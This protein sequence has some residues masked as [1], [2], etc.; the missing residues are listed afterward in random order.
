[1]TDQKES[2]RAAIIRLLHP[3]P[4]LAF[5]ILIGV[6]ALIAASV[7]DLR[8]DILMKM[9]RPEF[10]RGL[11]T[12]LFAVVTIGTAVVLV[13]SALQSSSD[14]EHT[15]KHFQRGK[16]ILGLLLGVFGTIVGYY[17]GTEAS[18]GGVAAIGAMTVS[19][20]GIDPPSATGGDSVSLE[21][22]VQGGTAPYRYVLYFADQP[23]VEGA[24]DVAGRFIADFAV[25]TVTSDTALTLRLVVFDAVRDSVVTTTS[26]DV[27]NPPGG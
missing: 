23:L 11:I 13:V 5:I 25:P 19:A 8:Y 22:Y 3:V 16:D 4:F 15:D 6:F 2:F 10:A 21:A 18:G 14:D 17:F 26:I 7:L 27:Q 20:P 24:V 9:S 1:M 12:Y